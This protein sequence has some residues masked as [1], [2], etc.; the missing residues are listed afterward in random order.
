MH[1]IGLHGATSLSYS[2][3][4]RRWLPG[5]TYDTELEVFADGYRLKLVDPYISPV[6]YVRRPGVKHEGIGTFGP[7]S[8]CWPC[9]SWRGSSIR[10]SGK[11]CLSEPILNVYSIPFSH[12]DDPFFSELSTIIDAMENSTK[13]DEIL[14]SYEDAVRTYEFVS[15]SFEQDFLMSWREEQQTWQIR[16]ASDASAQ[17]YRGESFAWIIFTVKAPS[18]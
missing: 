5:T 17:L 1:V 15:L 2:A 8:W 3:L 18:S 12:Q 4:S 11:H 6:L 7:N 13:K 10:R 14:S 16:S 9:P